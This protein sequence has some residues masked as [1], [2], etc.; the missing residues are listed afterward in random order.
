[1]KTTLF[2]AALALSATALAQQDTRT[3]S[4][5]PTPGSPSSMTFESL[6]TNADGRISASEAQASP[7]LAAKFT[8]IDKQS[9]GYITREEYQ[10]F[11]RSERDHDTSSGTSNR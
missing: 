9:K 2:F 3:P 11:M 8:Q 4:A 5:T 7:S 6:D 1:M 10:S